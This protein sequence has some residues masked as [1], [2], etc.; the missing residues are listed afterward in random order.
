MSLFFSHW[1]EC[2]I[3]G[4]N[5]G[6]CDCTDEQK[7]AYEKQTELV[8]TAANVKR[9]LFDAL[10]ED[11]TGE[12]KVNGVIYSLAPAIK[13]DAATE[14]NYDGKLTDYSLKIVDEIGQMDIEALFPGHKVRRV[15]W[16]PGMKTLSYETVPSFKNE[17]LAVAEATP[18]EIEEAIPSEISFEQKYFMMLALGFKS[19]GSG[20]WSHEK[21]D[22]FGVF[23]FDFD[24]D[25][26]DIRDLINRIM[27]EGIRIGRFQ[28]K[29][30]FKNLLS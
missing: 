12:K 17:P 10:V 26:D 1:S 4:H 25:K 22:S 3:C 21:V 2:S 23:H 9:K 14:E 8:R 29:Q 11:L 19:E 13:F 18:V 28:I 16:R 6:V 7:R 27:N 24:L 20:K 5:I 30:Q 15:P